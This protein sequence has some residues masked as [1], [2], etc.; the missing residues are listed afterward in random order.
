MFGTLITGQ[1]KML[2]ICLPVCDLFPLLC[3][4]SYWG[5]KAFIEG[6]FFIQVEF[7]GGKKVEL[8]DLP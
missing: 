8:S 5:F 1:L 4:L 3:F 2:K 6:I 7:S